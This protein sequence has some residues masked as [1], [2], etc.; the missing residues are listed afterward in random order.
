[1]W[2]VCVCVSHIL[3]LF[4]RVC[5]CVNNVH[6]TGMCCVCATLTES[7]GAWTFSY[8][9]AYTNRE[10]GELSYTIWYFFLVGKSS[11]ELFLSNFSISSMN[12][13][14]PANTHT[15]RQ[16]YDVSNIQWKSV[17]CWMCARA[18][19]SSDRVLCTQTYSFFGFGSTWLYGRR[20]RHIIIR[21]VGYRHS[22]M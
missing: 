6:C 21:Y 22:T 9:T 10:W 2:S 19:V 5:V 16:H 17:L 8:Y 15:Q 14:K 20:R 18:M 13:Q 3:T 4:V 12:T 7:G 1:M 11:G